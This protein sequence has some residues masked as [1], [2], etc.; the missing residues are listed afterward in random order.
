MAVARQEVGDER[1][2][3]EEEQREYKMGEVS[4]VRDELLKVMA[5]TVLIQ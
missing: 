5:Q 1:R 3:K 2:V 4:L